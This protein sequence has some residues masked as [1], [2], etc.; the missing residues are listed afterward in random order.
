M[1]VKK[2]PLEY[3][4]VEG[5]TGWKV[6]YEPLIELCNL[7][8]IKVLQVKEKFGGMRFYTY[9]EG[10]NDLIRAAESASYHTCEVC[11]ESGVSGWATEGK[12][13]YKVTTC[14]SR[15]SS[16]TRS[17]CDPCREAWDLKREAE[18]K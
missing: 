4:G 13:I 15:T 3:G 14:P 18:T 9:G 16:W 1:G 2:H 7:K 12:P 8:G 6:L 11:V 17:L 5:G 10:L